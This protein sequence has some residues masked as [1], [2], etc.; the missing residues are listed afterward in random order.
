MGGKA[1]VG[2]VITVKM[3]GFKNHLRNL[4]NPRHDFEDWDR[5]SGSQ[6]RACQIIEACVASLSPEQHADMIHVGGPGSSMGRASVV[7]Y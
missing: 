4:R 2:N 1:V 6:Q 5:F 3:H 7:I